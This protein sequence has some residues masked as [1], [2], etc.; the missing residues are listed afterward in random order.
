MQAYATHDV[1]STLR[2][3]GDQYVEFLR[4]SS[5]SMGLYELAAGAPDLQSPHTEDEVYYVVN[6]RATVRVA[7]EDQTIGPGSIIFVAANVEHRFHSIT[8]D[9]SVLVFFAPAE[10]TAAK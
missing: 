10:S 7:D 5:L 1:Q 6:G 8:E 9:L 4:A 3:S 2:A